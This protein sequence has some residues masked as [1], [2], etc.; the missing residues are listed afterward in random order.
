[1]SGMSR[2]DPQPS[3]RWLWLPLVVAAVVIAGITGAWLLA[4][5]T[6]PAYAQG[7]YL[8]WWF[9][10]PWLFVVPAFL[11]F[12]VLRWLL[13]GGWGWGWGRY[14]WGYGDPAVEILRERFA[15]GE[16]TKEQYDSMM[17]DLKG[18]RR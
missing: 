13:W 11:L 2:Y 4:W 9:P 6:A 18:S 15:R 12:F 3:R 10:F 16:I 5:P 14:R 17:R 7:A 8:W 1:M